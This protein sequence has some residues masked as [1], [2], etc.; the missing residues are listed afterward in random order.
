MGPVGQIRTLDDH[1]L[2]LKAKMIYI[3][4]EHFLLTARLARVRGLETGVII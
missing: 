2:V 3:D 4:L 1:S